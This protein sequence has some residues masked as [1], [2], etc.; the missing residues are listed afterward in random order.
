MP[1][2]FLTIWST[3]HYCFRITLQQQQQLDNMFLLRKNKVDEIR[4]KHWGQQLFFFCFDLFAFL[5]YSYLVSMKNWHKNDAILMPL[6]V[7]FLPLLPIRSQSMIYTVLL[8][9]IFT[10]HSQAA[11]TMWKTTR[12]N[13][14][15]IKEGEC[16]VFWNCRAKV[17]SWNE[18]ANRKAC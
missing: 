14:N 17:F 9:E 2:N 6:L 13:W 7:I 5:I 11:K 4:G 8:F 10:I 15:N 18:S 3:R 12:N 1:F 16:R